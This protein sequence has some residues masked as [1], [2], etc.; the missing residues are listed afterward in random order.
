[1]NSISGGLAQTRLDLEKGAGTGEGDSLYGSLFAITWSGPLFGEVILTYGRHDVDTQRATRIGSLSQVAR[2]DRDAE[3][4]T[5]RVTL[6]ADTSAIGL[7]VSPFVTADYTYLIEDD[8]TESGAS[9]LN[10]RGAKRRTDALVGELGVRAA[11]DRELHRRLLLLRR[12][13]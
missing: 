2:A 1:M 6:G 12:S 13:S 3:S 8:F 9:A 7:A 11:A 10:L 4:Y 5:A